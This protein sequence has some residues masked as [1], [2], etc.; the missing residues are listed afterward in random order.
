LRP[1]QAKSLTR[2]HLSPHE[3]GVVVVH[4]SSQLLHSVNRRIEVHK[5]ETPSVK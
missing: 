5:F 1:A 4:L 3:L 2:P